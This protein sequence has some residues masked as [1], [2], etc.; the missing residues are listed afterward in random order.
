MKPLTIHCQ[1]R[2]AMSLGRLKKN[3]S[4]SF[5]SAPH[6]QASRKARPSVACHTPIGMVRGLTGALIA[7]EH[8]LPQ[9]APDRAE[10]FVEARLGLD[11]YEVARPRQIPGVATNEPAARPGRGE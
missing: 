10:Q 4:S 6:S 1:T 11:I 9:I 5:D 2:A 8:L 3:L 7:G